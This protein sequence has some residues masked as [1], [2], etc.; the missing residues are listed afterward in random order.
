MPPHL[1]VEQGRLKDAKFT[2]SPD[3]TLWRIGR[4][5]ACEIFLP[6]DS[7]YPKV[8]RKHAVITCV[9]GKYYI[10]DG[11]GDR[12]KSHN[13]TIVNHEFVDLPSKKLLKHNDA[14]TICH[15]VLTFHDSVPVPD[16]D[17][18]S[19][20]MLAVP[21]PNE[22]SDP[23]TAPP[24]AQFAE[25]VNL[26][27]HSFDLDALLAR[28]VETMLK[29]FKRAE[30]S[31]VIRVDE[32]TRK[33]DRVE[34]FRS[35]ITEDGAPAPYNQKIV[36]QCLQTRQAQRSHDPSIARRSLCTP[37]LSGTGEAFGVL[38]LDTT[39]KKNFSPT[40]LHVLEALAN[41]VSYAFANSR[42][43]Q[44][45]LE[46]AERRRDLILAAEV[47]ES[48]LPERL[49]EIPGYE[50]FAAY[51]PVVEV[52]G[53]YY[54]FVPLGGNRLGILVADVAG[55]GVP[56]ALVMTRFSAQVRA[57]LPTQADLAGAV[58]HL[59]A[60]AQPLGNIEKFITMAV[61]QLDPATHT[62]TLVNAGHPA[63]LLLR[64]SSGA[65]EEKNPQI[66]HGVM[67]GALE[68]YEY[69]AFQFTLEPGDTL[70]IYSDGMDVA[71][72]AE[73][74]R[75][76]PFSTKGI[77]SAIEGSGGAP[78]ELGEQILRAWDKHVAGCH[79]HDDITLVC[80]GR[81]L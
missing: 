29:T 21:D 4:E 78:R 16:S 9:D 22:D 44:M 24:A 28:V 59:N 73:S 70:I 49:P 11:D 13:R 53:D 27:R 38:L 2:L 57:Y 64:R 47:V 74:V 42:Y 72:E 7:P 25:L 15:Y 33:A 81:T 36:D 10:K 30:R 35:R 6:D 5:S 26:L 39:S 54:D 79:Q 43:Y 8:S 60:L 20:V 68:R 63:P 40:D 14:I 31:F 67:L 69:E 62:V 56:A 80:F 34:E 17:S 3:R 45:A 50:F 19:T 51:E 46:L 12:R 48:F 76:R 52:G 66:C 58:R 37:L 55:H 77:R 18:P 75:P 1:L 61:L 65:V 23:P 41:H 71:M 32:A